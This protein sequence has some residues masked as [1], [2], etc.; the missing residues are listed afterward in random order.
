MCRLAHLYLDK[1][2]AYYRSI[3][4][5]SSHFVS[6]QSKD[7]C[8]FESRVKTGQNSFLSY[9]PIVFRCLAATHCYWIRP[10]LRIPISGSPV[11]HRSNQARIMHRD[12]WNGMLHR[13][14]RLLVHGA[15]K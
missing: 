5:H 9:K 7:E 12:N 1:H 3:E 14:G 13:G 11:A 2:G 4:D 15:K 6:F 10:I 8:C